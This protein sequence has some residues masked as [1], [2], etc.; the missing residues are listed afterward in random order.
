MRIIP[1]FL[2]PSILQINNQKSRVV[3]STNVPNNVSSPLAPLAYDTVSFG[4]YQASYV[5]G[6]SI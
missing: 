6:F 4:R 3:V 1:T 5:L 2:N